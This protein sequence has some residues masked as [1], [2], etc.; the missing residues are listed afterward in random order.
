MVRGHIILIGFMGS[1]KSTVGRLLARDLAWELVDSDGAIEAAE[2]MSVREM[3]ETRGEAYFRQRERGF[4]EALASSAATVVATGGGMPIPGD[5]LERLKACGRVVYLRAPF[6]VLLQRISHCAHRP[7]AAG[8]EETLK[9]LLDSRAEKYE[10]AHLVVD[11]EGKTPQ[12]IAGEI[13][14][15]LGL[16]VEAEH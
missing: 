6:A 9:K 11:T 16:E 5:N 7:L 2:G 12:Q 15:R 13:I 8:G 3:F 10:N 4:I 14:S 1:G